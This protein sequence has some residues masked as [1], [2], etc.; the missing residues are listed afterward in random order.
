MQVV[1]LCGGKGTRMKEITEDIPKPLVP[2]GGKPIIWHIMKNYMHY[3]FNEFILL[4]GYK[5]YKIKEFF[6]NYRWKNSNLTLDTRNGEENITYLEEE[7][8]KISF[9]DTGENTMTGGRIKQISNYVN[10]RF[11]LTYGDGLSN[12]NIK[13]LLDYHEKKG[14]I[15]T[16][17]GIKKNSQ[18]GI[19]DINNGLVDKF[20]EKP[21]NNHIINGGF[22][23]FEPEFFSYLENENSSILEQKPLMNLAVDK[24]LAV[25]NHKGFWVAMD[26]YK[27]VLEVEKMWSE[28]KAKWKVW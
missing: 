25:Y 26:T 11:F 3:G 17:T 15:G 6:L 16:V 27:D 14:R 7:K 13:E 19:L 2:I 21:E 1:I 23:V 4:L 9:I 22:F 12:I 24:E 18:Y 20:S 5:G 8:W 28:G 10:E